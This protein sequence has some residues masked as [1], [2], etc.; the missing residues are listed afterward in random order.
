MLTFLF[1][2]VHCGIG[3]LW[4]LWHW[5]IHTHGRQKN[6]L[7]TVN[8]MTAENLSTQ[9]VKASANDQGCLCM[10]YQVNGSVQDL[11]LVRLQW[12]S[13]FLA[14]THQSVFHT[15]AT[16]TLLIW[17]LY[18]ES[19][20]NIW[21]HYIQR[22]IYTMNSTWKDDQPTRAQGETNDYSSL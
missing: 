11:T 12:S 18:I 21:L 19:D 15:V 17:N 14:L 8:N 22:T 7:L 10:N 20:L 9:G 4:D 2:M 13:V 3:A 6:A 5:S 16:C 1:W